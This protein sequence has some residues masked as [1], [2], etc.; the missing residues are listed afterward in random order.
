[1]NAGVFGHEET[2]RNFLASR[3]LHFDALALRESLEMKGK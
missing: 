3:Q 1:L 2:R